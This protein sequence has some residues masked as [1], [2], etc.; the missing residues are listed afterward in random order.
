MSFP[1][2][3]EPLSDFDP[4]PLFEELGLVVG[5][6]TCAGWGAGAAVVDGPPGP[7]PPEPLPLE[8]LDPELPEPLD[9]DPLDPDPLDPEPLDPDPPEPDP[10][11]PLEPDP[12]EPEPEEPEPFEPEPPDPR[13][14]PVTGTVGAGVVVATVVVVV[15]LVSSSW[16]AAGAANTAVTIARVASPTGVVRERSMRPGSHSGGLAAVDREVSHPMSAAC[17]PAHPNGQG[18][19]GLE[20]SWTERRPP[21][22]KEAWPHPRSRAT[23]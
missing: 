4:G 17:H 16:A 19:G 21:G 13:S 5:T 15:V 18:T 7:L 12:P 14:L 20:V 6:G 8:P 10:P 9:P 23:I 1:L 3:E 22:T 11:E 2:R